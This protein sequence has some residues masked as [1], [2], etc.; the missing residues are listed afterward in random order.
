M[1]LTTRV[2]LLVPYVEKEDAK[3]LGARWDKDRKVWFAPPG[4]DPSTLG[5]WLPKGFTPPTAEEPTSPSE[6][7]RGTALIDLLA[8]VR[9]AIEQGLPDTV[10]VRAEVSELRGKNGHVYLSLAERNERGDVLAQA[11][12]VIWK[13]RAADIAAKFERATGEGLR[14]DIKILCQARVRFDVLYGLDLIIEDVDPSYTLGDLAAKLAR[15][16]ERLRRDGLYDRNKGLPAPVEF[17]RVAV[18]SPST[19]AGLGDFRR[20]TDRLQHAGLCDFHYYHATF[21]GTEAPSSI[22]TAVNEAL[23][24]HRQR[25][26]D[27]LVVI[28]GG[29]SV[30][31][32][33][34]LNDL[35]LALLLCRSPIPV[36]TGIGHERD[37][38]ILDEVAH[39]RF[40]TPSKVAL[41]I[42]STIKDNALA[43]LA[44]LDRI[45]AQVGR[46]LAR[47]RTTLEAQADRIEVGVRSAI[48]RAANDQRGHMAVIRTA[49]TYQLREASQAVMAGYEKVI[50]G[51]EDTLCEAGLGLARLSE[52]IAQRTQMHLGNEMAEVERLAQAVTLKAQAGLQAAG[53]DLDHLKAQAG[54]DATRLVTQ[55][56]ESLECDLAAVAVGAGSL[57][58]AARKEIEASTRM[59]VGLGPQATLRA[60]LRHRP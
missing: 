5:R 30:T 25:P 50:A 59:V 23:A 53:R 16:R 19:S 7:E 22:R 1:A 11:K 24:A 41:H 48:D 49:A 45:E 14:T 2:D 36:F 33:A 29:G 3:A 38:T 32:L 35:E 9:E 31:D 13:S 26:F 6:P 21:Q 47:E 8:Q 18:I 60:G 40:D 44:D 17:V 27:A 46:I 37:G 56:A 58:E 51:A 4:V 28:R 20:E 55:A 54:R 42:A 10:W 12:G 52:S 39:R 57:V 15:I 34:W 43:A